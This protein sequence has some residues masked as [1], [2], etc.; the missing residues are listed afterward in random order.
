MNFYLLASS[1]CIS[2]Q[3]C[4][5]GLNV[6]ISK[7]FA[8]A[9]GI[10]LTLLDMWH[11]WHFSRCPSVWLTRELGKIISSFTIT[12]LT[13]SLSIPDRVL[14]ALAVQSR[15]GRITPHGPGWV[16]V[17]SS[18]SQRRGRIMLVIINRSVSHTMY[19]SSAFWPWTWSTFRLRPR[20]A[21]CS[22]SLTS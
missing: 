18:Q 9:L 5:V 4:H 1:V 16:H 20:T 17:L 6:R 8:S 12:S 13:F 22:S 2:E 3:S 11:L 10:W 14:V 21:H 7:S 15:T 19:L